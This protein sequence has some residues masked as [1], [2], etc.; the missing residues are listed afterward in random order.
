V[1]GVEKEGYSTKDIAEHGQSPR[2]GGGGGGTTREEL[3]GAYG[4][5]GGRGQARNLA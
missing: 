5:R 3:T 2:I 1:E 4:L